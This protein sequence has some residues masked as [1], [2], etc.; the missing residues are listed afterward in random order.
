[1][2]DLLKAYG[3]DEHSHVLVKVNLSE[4]ATSQKPKADPAL[5]GRLVRAVIALT[6]RCAVCEC[7]QGELGTLLHEMGFGPEM[8]SGRLQA[9]DLDL[10]CDSALTPVRNRY[11]CYMIPNRLLEYDFRIAMAVASKRESCLFSNCVKL[12]VGIIPYRTMQLYPKSFHGW[13]PKIH[14]DLD[15]QICG[16]Y[17]AVT[18]FAPFHMFLSGGNAFLESTGAFEMPLYN[19]IDAVQVDREVLEQI[20]QIETPLYLQQ[21]LGVSSPTGRKIALLVIDMQ[22]DYCSDEGFYALKDGETFTMGSTAERLLRRIDGIPRDYT[23]RSAMVYRK[24]DYAEEPCIEGTRGAAFYGEFTCDLAFSNQQYS[25]FS[26]PIFRDFL[27]THQIGKLLIAGFQASFCV[28]ATAVT[29][30]DLGFEVSL[31]CDCI[32]ER[33][34][35]RIS[36]GRVFSTLQQNGCR[37]ICS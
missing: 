15:N 35:H 7:A 5:L 6:G 9:I 14:M 33:E 10:E 27:R 29:A 4:P 24:R 21:S 30:L 25:C 31:L 34:K 22:N 36:A 23:I 26:S 12:F 20:F 2:L 17:C 19:G 28:A 3:M 16:I 1:M 18:Q 11:G 8:S 13:R 37:L 32:G